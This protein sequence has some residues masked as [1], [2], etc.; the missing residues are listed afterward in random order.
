MPAGKRS[1]ASVAKGSAER[2]KKKGKYERK[3]SMSKT[4]I[5]RQPYMRTQRTFWIQN[6]SP[7]TTTTAGFWQFWVT[8]LQNVQNYAQY[9]AVF[10]KYKVNSLKFTFRPRYDN[11][12]GNDTVDTTLPG[13]TNQ[14]GV[15]LHA[16][17]DP[18]S[19]VSPTGV[20]DSTN[21][22]TFLEQGKARTYKGT[23]AVDLLIKYPCVAEDSNGTTNARY[24]RGKWYSTN[25]PGVQHRGVH[26]FLQDVN[27]T[28]VFGQSFDVFCTMDISFAG[29]K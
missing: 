26:V 14:A 11:F 28:G 6:W 21:L 18:T 13:V 25:L 9:T 24:E 1:Y 8:S 22:N 3:S 19:N 2:M 20:Y 7:N 17:I 15:M 5:G 12:A 27:L 4:I 29:M 16:I 10:D 23:D